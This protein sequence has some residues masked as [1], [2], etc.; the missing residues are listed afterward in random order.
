MLKKRARKARKAP[1]KKE[2][3]SANFKC[4]TVQ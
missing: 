4:I 1:G 2:A 3:K